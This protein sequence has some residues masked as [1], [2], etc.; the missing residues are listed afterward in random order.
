[1]T[2]WIRTAAMLSLV[3]AAACGGDD[4][5]TRRD[6]AAPTTTTSTAVST[7]TAEAGPSPSGPDATA[8]EAPAPDHAACARQVQTVRDRGLT[9]DFSGALEMLDEWER[10]GCEAACGPLPAPTRDPACLP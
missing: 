1:M 8:V 10:S 3:V 6:D 7:T 5:D 2:R 9:T 4:A